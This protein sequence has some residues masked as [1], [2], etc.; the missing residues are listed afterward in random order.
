MKSVPRTLALAL[1]AGAI[2]LPSQAQMVRVTV[3][4]LASTDP[5]GMHVAPV[6]LGFHDGSF[7]IFDSGTAASPGVEALAELGD[8]SMIDSAFTSAQPSGWSMV[9]NNPAGPGPGIFTPGD[10]NSVD[11]RVDS[12]SRGYLS[13]GAMLVPSNDTFIANGNPMSL[14]LFDLSGTFLGA[15]SWTITGANAYDSG[16]EM[17]DPNDGAAFVMGVDAMLGTAENGVI[18]AQPL[19]GL[20]NMIGLTTA[21]GTV[22][23]QG[24]TG[25]PLFRISITPVPEPSTY[26]AIAGV[27]LLGLIVWQKR[28][29]AAANAATPA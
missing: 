2:A 27:A 8:S 16:T 15:Q 17:N 4:N 10:S 6:W 12:S 5:L 20:D 1:L 22:M 7:D 13:Y 11:V 24:L 19:D 26:G 9:L 21:A 18:H 29:R 3:K 28:R 25:D 23:G 14:A